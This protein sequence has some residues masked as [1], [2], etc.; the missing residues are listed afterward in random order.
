MIIFVKNKETLLID[1][2]KLKCVVGKKGFNKN[3]KE[4]DNTTPVGTFELGDIYYRADRIQRPISKLKTITIKKNMGW[5][6]DPESKLSSNYFSIGINGQWSGQVFRYLSG[7]SATDISG[8]D[9]DVQAICNAA[10]TDTNKAAYK[11]WAEAN[12]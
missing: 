7:G 3:K 1:D 12:G 9:A 11:T 10:W 5:C 4:G 8:L 6:D 2:F